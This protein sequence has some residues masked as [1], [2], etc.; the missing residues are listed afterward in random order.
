VQ[1]EPWFQLRFAV[2]ATAPIGIPWA[3]SAT[4]A[5]KREPMPVQT[6]KRPELRE[7]IQKLLSQLVPAVRDGGEVPVTALV[8]A[9]AGDRLRDDV[10]RQLDSRKTAVF[11]KQGERASFENVGPELK[12]ELSKFDIKIPKRLAGTAE[13]TGDGATLRFAGRDTLSAA[14]FFFSVKL[15]AL[16]LTSKR[17]FIDMEGDSFDQ[18]YE[19][20]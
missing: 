20:V 13:L 11:R 3:L 9:V 17:V 2:A 19:L 5:E 18:I 8:E 14:K 6:H 4:T 10:R 16:E 12:I 1:P 15:E 7:A